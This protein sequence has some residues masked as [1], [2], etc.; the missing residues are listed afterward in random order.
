MVPSNLNA[1]HNSRVYLSVGKGLPLPQ[2]ESHDTMS[3]S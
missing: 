1:K 3:R 2:I